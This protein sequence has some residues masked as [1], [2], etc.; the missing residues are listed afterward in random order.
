LPAAMQSSRHPS[1]PPYKRCMPSMPAAAAV[2]AAAQT[3]PGKAA[4]GDLL[5]QRSMSRGCRCTP[6]CQCQALP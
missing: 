3:G 1:F 5:Q 6:C 2:A 4:G